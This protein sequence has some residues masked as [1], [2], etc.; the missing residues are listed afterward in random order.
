MEMGRVS[1]LSLQNLGS[2]NLGAVDEGNSI[3]A[4]LHYF[5][6]TV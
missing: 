4:S 6:F 1:P 5:A 3:T 2:Q